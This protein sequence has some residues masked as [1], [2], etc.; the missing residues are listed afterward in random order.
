ME[1][2]DLIFAFFNYINQILTQIVTAIDGIILLFIALIEIILKFTYILPYP[3]YPCF[4][5]FLGAYSTILIFK[6][7][8]KGG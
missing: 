8:R 3:F 5:A 7:I 4:V 2:F 1:I 6:L